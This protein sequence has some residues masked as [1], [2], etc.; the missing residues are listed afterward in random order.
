MPQFSRIAIIGLLALMQLFAPLVHAHAGGG[1]FSGAIHLPGLE[2]LSQAEEGSA[3]SFTHYTSH[4]VIVGLAQGVKD[5]SCHATPTPDH[6]GILLANEWV[7]PAFTEPAG[8]LPS[9]L[10]SPPQPNWL[11]TSPRAP[12]KIIA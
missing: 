4:D 6:D 2:F 10:P 1:Q 7:A 8:H 11:K 9:F 12:P 5:R 3:Q